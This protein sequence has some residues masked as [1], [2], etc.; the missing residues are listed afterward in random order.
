V[1]PEGKNMSTILLVDDSR[2]SREVLKVFLIGKNVTVL[3]A[4]DGVEAMRIVHERHPDLVVADLLMPRLDG[5]GLC[6]ELR[7]DARTRQT[8]VLVLTGNADP[9]TEARCKAA[10]AREVLKKPIQ[11]KALLEAIGRHLPPSPNV[12]VLRS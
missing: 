9:D 6:E 5:F 2:V 1:I 8:P 3:E 12:T 4:V 11:P 10:G 7:A